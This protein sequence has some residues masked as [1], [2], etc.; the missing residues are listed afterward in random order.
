MD[1]DTD[2]SVSSSEGTSS[3]AREEEMHPRLTECDQ[4]GCPVNNFEIVGQ[5]IKNIVLY[6]A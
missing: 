3:Y 5:I 4:N 6:L 1:D 2:L